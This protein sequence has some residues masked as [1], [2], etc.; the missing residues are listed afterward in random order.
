MVTQIDMKNHSKI[1]SLVTFLSFISVCILDFNIGVNIKIKIDNKINLC[2][3]YYCNNIYPFDES[4]LHEEIKNENNDT[5]ES[6]N[7]KI[8]YNDMKN[9]LFKSNYNNSTIISQENLN[10]NIKLLKNEFTNISNSE[11]TK[12][13]LQMTN[14]ASIDSNNQQLIKCTFNFLKDFRFTRQDIKA[15]IHTISFNKCSSGIVLNFVI[16]IAFICST[17]ITS[18]MF[19]FYYKIRRN[20][21]I[22]TYN[23]SMLTSYYDDVINNI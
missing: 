14:Q 16:Q 13:L 7:L 21:Y 17:F 23:N 11:L 2:H 3:P 5:I 12:L 1:F 19:S 8:P 18:I 20:D 10:S 22:Q 4:K 15:R 9:L 6:T